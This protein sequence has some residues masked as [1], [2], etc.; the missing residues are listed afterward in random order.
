MGLSAG[1]NA[2]YFESSARLQAATMFGITDVF[3]SLY[4]LFSFLQDSI[5]DIGREKTRNN[6]ICTE[7]VVAD[8]RHLLGVLDAGA[9]KKT[10][11]VATDPRQPG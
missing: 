6:G 8:F 11:P 9:A 4:L 10:I 5:T 2:Y 7:A 3:I 1:E